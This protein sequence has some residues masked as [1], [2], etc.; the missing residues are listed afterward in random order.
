MVG[1]HSRTAE[2]W[3]NTSARKEILHTTFALCETCAELGTS[4]AAEPSAPSAS[5]S[6]TLEHHSRT[7]ECYYEPRHSWPDPTKKIMSRVRNSIQQCGCDVLVWR[8]LARCASLRNE[9]LH[10]TFALWETCAEL[11]TSLAAEPSAQSASARSRHF[12]RT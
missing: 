1:H 11:G 9:I 12:Y 7:A 3:A 2:C 10:K 8:C 6:A 4:L 5:A